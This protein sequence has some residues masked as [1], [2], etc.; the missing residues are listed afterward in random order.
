[1]RKKSTEPRA[2]TGRYF[3]LVS[4]I[5]SVVFLAMTTFSLISFEIF[6]ALSNPSISS[7]SCVTSP[8][9]EASLNR[10]W[11][12]SSL[13][14][15]LNWFCCRISSVLRC[16][17]SGRSRS[18]VSASSWSSRPS[19]VTEKFTS[20]HSAWISGAKC[21]LLSLVCR[22]SR[23]LGSYSTSSPPS[24]MVHVRLLF[25]DTARASSGSSVASIS[26]PRFSMITVLP[27]VTAVTMRRSHCFCVVCTTTRSL[28]SSRL[29]SHLMPCTCG[30]IMSGHR[31]QLLMMAPFSTDTVS[32]GRPW[33]IMSATLPSST[34]M[35]S[36]RTPS[37]VGTSRCSRSGTH[38]CR[39]SCVRY[40]WSKPPM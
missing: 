14:L 39:H 37:V 25:L 23:N 27:C 33:L 30:S 18:T 20:V 6:L 36:G 29:R 1:M 10:I 8:S 24:L 12:S 38:N 19:S 3:S 40:W 32:L 7:T 28:P 13:I 4:L 34:S 5:S 16:A 22:Y 35:S 21:G 9:A 26:S 15:T 11:S 2:A 17:R 31:S